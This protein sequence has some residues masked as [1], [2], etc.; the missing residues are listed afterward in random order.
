MY[1]INT[2]FRMIFASNPQ[3][4]IKNEPCAFLT[5]FIKRFLWVL[6]VCSLTKLRRG[7]HMASTFA[8][9][10]SKGLRSHVYKFHQQR[11]CTRRHQLAFT[12]LAGSFWDKLP[13]K[14]V[15]ASSGK[16]FK[17]LLDAHWQSLSPK[18]PSNPPPPII[19]SLNTH[20][21]T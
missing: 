6:W 21:P 17:A 12:I 5:V 13:A 10:T 14:I 19:H 16:S 11:C 15:N 2:A 20:R 4:Q 8:H 3:Q 9:L 18:N 7:L 1:Y